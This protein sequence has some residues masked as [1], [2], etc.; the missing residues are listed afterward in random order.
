MNDNERRPAPPPHD[1]HHDH[2]KKKKKNK[3]TGIILFLVLII[4]ILV[5]LIWFFRRGFGLGGS[6]SGNDS[7]NSGS[8]PEV[9]STDTNSDFD[10]DIT[11]IRIDEENIYFGDEKC[12]DIDD[13]EQKI[14]N[15]GSGKKY[16]LNSDKAIQSTYKDVEDLLIKLRDALDLEVDLSK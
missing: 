5:A 11:E 16:K 6:G 9:S 8:T 4:I 3:R 15:A 2:K 7:G 12:A 14:T 13:L 10:P 1:D